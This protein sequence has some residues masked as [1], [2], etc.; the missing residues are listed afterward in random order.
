MFGDKSFLS[1]N[2]TVWT[3]AA[4]TI[5]N[6]KG[7]SEDEKKGATTLKCHKSKSVVSYHAAERPKS[8]HGN[9]KVESGWS[10]RSEKFNQ[11]F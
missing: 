2:L 7:A 1:P 5:A 9:L 10:L 8:L 3:V 11:K 4:A 6:K